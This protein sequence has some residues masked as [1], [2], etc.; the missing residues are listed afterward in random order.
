V[1]AVAGLPQ[2]PLLPR[3][4]GSINDYGQTLERVHR[5]SLASYVEELKGKGLSFFYLA[6][7]RDPF[8]DPW[9]Y[10]REVFLHWGLPGDAVLVVFVLE[11]GRWRVAGQLGVDAAFRIPEHEFVAL[12]EEA[13]GVARR[14]PP[15]QAVL[16]LA[17]GLVALAE[18]GWS[19]DGGPKG[20]WPYAVAGGVGALVLFLL[21]RRVCPRCLRPLYRRPTVRG[22]IW[23]CPRCGYTRAPRRGRGT[24]S[25][26]GF[27]P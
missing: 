7:W 2:E 4:L 11:G 13:E 8:G 5:E 14:A 12:L 15:A 9:T 21:A 10:A 22:I 25:R 26:G 27:Y 18:G 1:L 19:G 23:V 17:E 20:A 16:A 24:G 6:S 3:R